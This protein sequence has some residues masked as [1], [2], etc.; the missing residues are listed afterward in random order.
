MD[1]YWLGAS[2]SNRFAQLEKP[3]EPVEVNEPR[4]PPIFV[5]GVQ[6]IKPLQ[7]LLNA[8]APKEHEIKIISSESVKI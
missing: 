6:N 4:P 8:I 7:E 1:G 2:T 5:T 3:E